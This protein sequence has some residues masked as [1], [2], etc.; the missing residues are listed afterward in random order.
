MGSNHALVVKLTATQGYNY[1]LQSSTNLVNW[2]PKA[3]LLITTGTV[4][5]ADPT[6]QGSSA[7]FYRAIMP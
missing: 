3:F 5:Y 1:V 7:R 6:W 2:A 4:L